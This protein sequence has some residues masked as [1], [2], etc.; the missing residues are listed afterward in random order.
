MLINVHFFFITLAIMYSFYYFTHY[1]LFT[2]LPIMYCFITMLPLSY[3]GTD[4]HWHGIVIPM[5]LQARLSPEDEAPRS[6]W[7]VGS[8]RALVHDGIY[9][10][11]VAGL[12]LSVLYGLK[13]GFSLF[14]S[15][16]AAS[17]PV[18]G[19]DL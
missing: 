17:T 18:R 1:V 16:L 13:L 11:A 6:G 3:E 19:R 9:T 15:P 7:R 4:T 14:R 2:T 8:G 5:L 10:C 12:F